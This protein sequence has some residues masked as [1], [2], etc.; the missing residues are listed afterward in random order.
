M[1]VGRTKGTFNFNLSRRRAPREDFN[2]VILVTSSLDYFTD[3]WTQA[4]AGAFV[5]GI[6]RQDGEILVRYPLL[7]TL[8]QNLAV[9]SPMLDLMQSSDD[10][11]YQSISSIDGRERLY[12]YSRIGTTPLTGHSL[13]P[14]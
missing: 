8:P 13:R 2:G 9:D 14:T 5:A 4:S 7:D 6:F 12:G 3:F 1:I 10:E 11:V